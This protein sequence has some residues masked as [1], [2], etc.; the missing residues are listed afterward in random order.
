MGVNLDSTVIGYCSVSSPIG[1]LFLAST[2]K[3]VCLVEFGTEQQRLPGLLTWSKKYMGSVNIELNEQM[4]QPVAEQLA[5]YFAGQ[6]Q[7]FELPIDLYGTV[8]QKQVWNQLSRIPYGQ[9]RS[10]KQIAVAMGKETAVRAVGGANN[11]NPISIIIPCHRVI[12]AN[13]SLV[14][15]GGGLAIKEYLLSLEG[16]LPTSQIG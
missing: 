2:V 10:Y 4:N 6:R 13:G 11:K 3:G 12:G 15:Y 9:T 5:E 1:P 14:G 8:F 7:I 16:I